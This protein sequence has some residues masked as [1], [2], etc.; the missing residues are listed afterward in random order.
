[1]PSETAFLPS[2]MPDGA[3]TAVDG[4]DFRFSSVKPAWTPA[5][6]NS[7][8]PGP[9]FV[10]A[11]FRFVSSFG[12]K[13]RCLFQAAQGFWKL[14][15][16][17]GLSPS[18]AHGFPSACGQA[19]VWWQGIFQ[20]QNADLLPHSRWT[21]RM[22]AFCRLAMSLRTPSSEADRRSL[23][24]LQSAVALEASATNGSRAGS[25]QSQSSRRFQ[26]SPQ[27]HC[28]SQ[29]TR[30]TLISRNTA[31]QKHFSCMICVFLFTAFAQAQLHRVAPYA[32]P[33]GQFSIEQRIMMAVVV[34]SR[35]T[36][37]S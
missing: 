21:A 18:L 14:S 20:T 11:D 19:V 5:G 7:I 6:P 15:E 4:A 26:G 27:L 33:S 31:T 30:S 1:M 24:T 17:C 2:I 25:S 3:R 22:I 34:L 13:P 12:L 32:R 8:R 37:I 29:L 23:A 35:T 9:G 36:S 10:A 16:S 28:P